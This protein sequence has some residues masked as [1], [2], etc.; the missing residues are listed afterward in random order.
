MQLTMLQFEIVAYASPIIYH[1][2]CDR[3][4]S[5]SLNDE[6]HVPDAICCLLDVMSD[7]QFWSKQMLPSDLSL[8]LGFSWMFT[9]NC[10]SS[11]L[12]LMQA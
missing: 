5:A 11:M 8:G 2:M 9:A 4:H 10:W 6:S 1:A 7:H 3:P 12:S